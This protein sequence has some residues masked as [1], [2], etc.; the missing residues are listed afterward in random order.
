MP[1]ESLKIRPAGEADVQLLVE[2]IRALAG[3]EKLLDEVV[4]T[5]EIVRESLCGK[6]PAAEALIGEWEGEP[7]AFAVYFENFSTFMG[8]SGLYLED[9][10]V[11]P[12][13]RQRGIGKGMLKHLA[14]I[15]VER[16]CPR[17]EWIA[18]DWN[19]PAIKFYEGLG[20]KQLTDKRCF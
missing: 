6:K 15:A 16:G 7:V 17:F 4:A 19:E 14:K 20:A 5:E 2:F 8:R 18:L 12:E 11:K 9:L 10:F 1:A 13:Y 3:Y